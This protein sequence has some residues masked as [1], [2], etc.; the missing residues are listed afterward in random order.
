MRSTYSRPVSL[1]S[2]YLT[3]EPRGIS[4]TALSTPGASTPGLRSCQGWLAAMRGGTRRQSRGHGIHNQLNLRNQPRCHVPPRVVSKPAASSPRRSSNALGASG[5][6][7]GDRRCDTPAKKFNKTYDDC[8]F[9][10]KAASRQHRPCP[11]P[12]PAR[13]T[14]AACW[15]PSN[16]SHRDMQQLL[17]ISSR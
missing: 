4:M 3:L 17:H 9:L 12:T 15:R 6:A 5:R 10:L 8:T 14:T 7:S 2:S 1:S 13:A 11:R 16:P